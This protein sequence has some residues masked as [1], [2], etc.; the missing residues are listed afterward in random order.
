LYND[1]IICRPH[2]AALL[3]GWRRQGASHWVT[4]KRSMAGGWG[5]L[6]AWLAAMYLGEACVSSH[7]ST[8]ENNNTDLANV[9]VWSLSVFFSSH[10]P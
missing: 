4:T 5:E 7:L 3:L 1:N 9:H 6:R 10:R 2:V 8:V